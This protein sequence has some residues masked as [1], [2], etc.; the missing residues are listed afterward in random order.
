VNNKFNISD[1]KVNALKEKMEVLSISSDDIEENFSLGSGKGGQ[2]LNKTEICVNLHHI[3][4]GIRVSCQKERERSKNRF[5]ALRLLVE[6]IEE[7][8]APQ[9]S[10][11]LKKIDKMRKQ[12]KRRQRRTKKKEGE[13]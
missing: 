5:L 13:E 2:K 9:D 10:A 6:R 12:K 4:T 8:Q 1:K 11:R 3:P 7:K